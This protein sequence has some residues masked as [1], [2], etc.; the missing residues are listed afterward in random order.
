MLARCHAFDW[1]STPLG[2]REQW[3]TSLKTAAGLVLASGFPMVLLWGPDL[4]QVYN[5]GYIPFLDAKHPYGLGI[6]NR[7]CWPEVWHI[8]A[9]VYDKVFAGETVSFQDAL[10]PVRRHGPDGPEEALYIT[11]SYSPVTDDVGA[12]GG[13]LVTL[14]DTTAHVTGRRAEAERVRL[15]RA[16]QHE[17][18]ALLEAAFR[19]APSFLAIYSGPEH[20]FALSNDAYGQL[21]G[22]ER[23]IIG[24][25]LLEALPEVVDQGFDVVL[26][27]VLAT[28]EPFT[29]HEAPVRLARTPGAPAEDRVVALTYLPVV[30]PDGR[31]SGVIAHGI[32]VTDYVRARREAERLLVESEQLRADAVGARA[33]AEQARERTE[34]LQALTAALAGAR[35]LDDVARVVVAETVAALGARTG[36]LAVRGAD[37]GTLRLASTFGY[38]APMP[39]SVLVQRLDLPSPLTEC[40][41]TCAPIWIER[42]DGPHGL[43]VR[44]P[45]TVWVWDKLGVTSGASIPLIAAGEAVGVICF[46]FSEP[47]TFPDS[48]R[49]F[50]LALGRQAALAVDRAR[51]SDAER[52]ARDEAE[53]ANQGKSEFLAVMS[54]ELRTPLNAIGGYAELIEMGIRGPVT[55]L[56]RADLSRIQKSQRH[57]LGLVNSVLDFAKVDA[58]AVSYDLADVLLSEVLATCEALIAPQAESKHIML[59]FSCVDASLAARA[60]H[61]KVERVVLNLLSNAVKFTEPHGSVTVACGRQVEHSGNEP[62]V[63]VTITDTGR[64]IPPDQIER[65]F[66]PF[67]QVDAKLTRTQEGTGLGLAISRDLARGMQGDLT[68]TST[69]GAG[70]TF[71]LALPAV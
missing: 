41:R 16:L 25:P 67:V 31:R 48:E 39:A 13:V 64:G 62:R 59:T 56:Q 32:D 14:L 58:G 46:A 50:L 34:R 71:T 52:T 68:V 30:E 49:D 38:P 70:S 1:A 12:V 28:G 40:F 57:L 8:N 45:P 20:V 22:P 3:S 37:D 51:L 27:R 65:V 33:E 18:T 7:A 4:I 11:L 55:E 66:Q 6:G 54:H 53:A 9:P 36:S 47:R 35:T 26:D 44:Y 23:D 19:G 63:I 29:V 43:D 17:R 42:R 15:E 61:K 21:V 5:D 60:D 10:Y 2:A 69:A 24:K